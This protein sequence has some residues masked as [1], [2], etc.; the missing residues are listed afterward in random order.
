MFKRVLFILLN[1]I[2]GGLL[3]WLAFATI[4][5]IEVLETELYDHVISN[6]YIAPL[7]A[8]IILGMLPLIF[9]NGFL[10]INSK[11]WHVLSFATILLICFDAFF[12][13]RTSFYQGFFRY[14]FDPNIYATCILV[15]YLATNYFKSQKWQLTG[16][17]KTLLYIF[18]LIMIVPFILNPVY[19]DDFQAKYEITKDVQTNLDSLKMDFPEF[20]N[21]EQHT[22][23]CF[24]SVT[25][26]FCKLAA[27]KLDATVRNQAEY[28]MVKMVFWGDSVSTEYFT[29]ITNA[30]S[31]E[32]IFLKD[33]EKFSSVAGR[34]FPHF[35]WVE[36]GE[37]VA[38][39]TGGP[40]NFGVIQTL[41]KHE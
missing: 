4:Y 14:P 40:F 9:L 35:K 20:F 31:S 24:Y 34:S 18:P 19:P 30:K 32:Y 26:G 3:A 38:D 6:W 36:H 15:L 16:G 37:I 12:V 41:G 8:R 5:P 10:N 22:L 11:V 27:L 25:C 2:L 29:R 28:P 1:T 13:E 33:G 39:W 23:Y 17:W 21:D 7:F